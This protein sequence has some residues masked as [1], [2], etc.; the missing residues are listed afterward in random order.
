M[1]EIDQEEFD[2]YYP[3]RREGELLDMFIHQIELPI[4][5]DLIPDEPV[6][7]SAWTDK[8]P[9]DVIHCSIK[10]SASK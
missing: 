2:Y 6:S 7:D 8:I 9:D 10:M 3:N 4:A 1:R 5:D